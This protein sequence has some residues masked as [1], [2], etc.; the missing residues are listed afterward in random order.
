MTTEYLDTILVECDRQSASI[1]STS[2]T[3]SW[4]NKQNSTL[5]LLPNDKVSVYSS[6]VNDVGSGQDNPIEFRGKSLNKTKTIKYTSVTAQSIKYVADVKK[7][8]EIYDNVDTIEQTIELKDNEASSIINFYKTMDG[9]NYIQLPRRFIPTTSALLASA[10]NEDRFWASPDSTRLGRTLQEFPILDPAGGIVKQDSNY[11]GYVPDDIRGFKNY[12]IPVLPATTPVIGEPIH[13]ILKNDNT[14]YTIMEKTR[15]ISPNQPG[16]VWGTDAEI[17]VA[18]QKTYHPPYYAREPEFFDYVIKRER[19]DLNTNVGFSAAKNI[20]DSLTK[21]F[22]STREL[23]REDFPQKDMSTLAPGTT[24]PALDFVLNKRVESNTYKTFEAGNEFLQKE[25]WYKRSLYNGPTTSLADVTAPVDGVHLVIEAGSV[26][27][28]YGV[29]KE[30]D[31]LASY[32]YNGFRFIAC[33]RPEIYETGSELNDIFGIPTS[34][35]LSRANKVDTGLVLDIPYFTT[36]DGTVT[37]VIV[38]PRTPSPQLLNFK[39][40]LESQKNYPELFSSETVR[41]ILPPTQN[42][43]FNVATG[44]SYINHSGN[45]AARFCHMDTFVHAD[46][47]R[48]A[49][50]DVVSYDVNR[51]DDPANP[52]GPKNEFWKLGQSYYNYAGTSQRA[53]TPPANPATFNRDI[54]NDKTQSSPFYFHYDNSQMEEFY[55]DPCS[56][57]NFTTSKFTYGAFGKTITGDLVSN[58]TNHIIIYPNLLTW[59]KTAQPPAPSINV[60]LPDVFFHTYGGGE[61]EIKAGTKMG[62]DRHWNAWGTAMI[63]L[64]SGKG[65]MGYASTTV[66]GALHQGSNPGIAGSGIAQPEVTF[67]LFGGVGADEERT[68]N[69]PQL[70]ATAY[71]NKLYCGADKPLL[72]FNGSYFYFEKLHTP[73]NRGNVEMKDPADNVLNPNFN[74]AEGAPDVYKI[75]PEQQY[76]MYSPAQF[77]Y[78]RASSYY[79]AGSAEERKLKRLNFNLEPLT[80]YDTTTGIYIE[81]FGYTE[82]TWDQGLW[83]RLGFTYSQFNASSTT[84][85]TQV[86][87]NNSSSLNIVTTNAEIDCVDTKSW[88]QNQFGVTKYNGEALVN[89]TIPVSDT[90]HGGGG[91]ANPV[92]LIRWIPP[93]NQEATS[94]QIAAQNYPISMNN[95]YYNIRSD[96][97]G[98]S[99]FV[100]GTGNTRMPIVSIVSKQNPVGDYYITPETDIQFTVTKPTRLSSINVQITEPDGSPA[101]V[102]ER[103]SVIFKIQRTRMLKTNIAQEVFEKLQEEVK[104]LK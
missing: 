36:T 76:E 24:A 66:N 30:T 32:Y 11:Y 73:L 97:T 56:K 34:E 102:S 49:N 92:Q 69:T 89:Y 98:T 25:E 61:I 51:F 75:N 21:Q 84:R 103:S 5:M 19:I 45:S 94:V 101:A 15:N 6:Y 4:T 96:I 31:D 39:A 40:F 85:L 79:L 35:N 64:Q 50:C 65:K 26:P 9:L 88:A 52:S 8:Y 63:N 74:A 95:G 16:L 72:G 70:D 38:E 87:N 83:G 29:Q 28:V 7:V 58:N 10:V 42:N 67:P 18:K 22:Q 46:D 62:F 55:T 48:Y 99:S 81:D 60:G 37:G 90:A 14:R 13:F 100:D 104:Q 41:Q 54:N 91:H 71:N 20:A 59:D 86:N 33:K 43:Y 82:D 27:Q 68:E 78:N 12:E 3:S 53:G 44:A 47:T 93:V 17:E 2:D 23:E 80:I 57:T 1:K 77:P